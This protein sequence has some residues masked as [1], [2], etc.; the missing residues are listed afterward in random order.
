MGILNGKKYFVNFK[1]RH[2]M[3]KF[4]FSAKFVRNQRQ[5]QAESQQFLKKIDDCD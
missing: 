1:F 4:S 2:N 3:Q 5:R